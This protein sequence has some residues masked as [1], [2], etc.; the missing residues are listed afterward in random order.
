L[1]GCGEHNFEHFELID[2]M[3]KLVPSAEYWIEA[4]FNGGPLWQPGDPVHLVT[5]AYDALAA[6]V[7][8]ILVEVSDEAD[9]EPTAKRQRLESVVVTVK[10]PAAPAPVQKAAPASRPGWS[11]G[12]L[13]RPASERGRGAN[14]RG[15]LRPF[16]GGRAGYGGPA[17]GPYRGQKRYFPW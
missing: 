9:L 8:E 3:E 12:E 17:R 6:K 15:R 14:R 2:S 1:Q 13:I 11:S 16:N 5:R 10:G 4:P 7:A